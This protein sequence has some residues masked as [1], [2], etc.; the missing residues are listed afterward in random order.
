MDIDP[1]VDPRSPAPFADP[2]RWYE[3][4]YQLVHGALRRWGVPLDAVDDAVQETFVA[5]YRRRAAFSGGSMPAWLYAIAR[6]IASNLRRTEARRGRRRAAL[7]HVQSSRT[8]PAAPEL[9][10]ALVVLER[11]L[12]TLPA[13]HRE[14]FAL[15]ELDGLTGPEIARCLGDN[16]ATTYGRVREVRR[17]FADYCDEP[18]STLASSRSQRAR[19][20]HALVGG[21]MER[22]T[23]SSAAVP[24]AAS[25]A[26]VASVAASVGLAAV[27]LLGIHGAAR[28]ASPPVPGVA[29]AGVHAEAPLERRT[30][31]A[32][33]PTQIAERNV[34]EP[35]RHDGAPAK[36]SPRARPKRI[37][38]AS[39]HPPATDSPRPR[40]RESRVAEPPT[41]NPAPPPKPDA[42]T[43]LSRV[44]I[45]I[46]QSRPAEALSL[47]KQHARDYPDSGLSDVRAALHI[48]ALCALGRTADADRKADAFLRDYPASAARTRVRSGCRT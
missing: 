8:A 45:A 48:E 13:R 7:T 28:M 26:P 12:E 27:V 6:R 31:P 20:T 1:D 46:R 19:P 40:P 39:G 17:R 43:A 5:A 35:R 32:D 18:E 24:V 16:L 4:H 10:A 29:V 34:E 44:A 2:R 21:F 25:S 11:F 37:A 41:A 33:A 9:G 47:A 30:P 22:L 14:V 23:S 36:G 42:A 3:E 38:P 15:S